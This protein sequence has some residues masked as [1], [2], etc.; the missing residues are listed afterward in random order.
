MK[1]TVLRCHRRHLLKTKEPFEKN[2]EIDC[3]DIVITDA[4]G[5][6]SEPST[7]NI[8]KELVLLWWPSVIRCM[9][10]QRYQMFFFF[11]FCIVQIN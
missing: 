2:C 3:D 11:N 9:V 8:E 4:N 10:A 7:S 5:S 1:I 6:Q